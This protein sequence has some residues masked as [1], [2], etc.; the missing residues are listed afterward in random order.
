MSEK[1]CPVCNSK[2]EATAAFCAFCGT[3]LEASLTSSITTTKRMDLDANYFSRVI[4]EE[5]VQSLE[6]PVKGISLFILDYIKPIATMEQQEFI[7]GRNR[8]NVNS[9]KFVD[10]TP[11]GGYEFGVSHR[12]ALIRKESSEY[13]IIDLDSTNGTLLNR[14]RIIP[15]RAYPLPT[16]TQIRIGKLYLYAV[17]QKIESPK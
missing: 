1:P 12:H 15:N 5:F 7:L 6:V 8:L 10:L 3:S 17:Y 4:E 13:V 11:Y 2:N 9:N 14:K 16:G